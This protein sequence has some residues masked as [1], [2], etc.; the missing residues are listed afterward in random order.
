MKHRLRKWIV[1]LIGPVLFIYLLSTCDLR[2]IARILTQVRLWPFMF[3]LILTLGPIMTRYLRWRAINRGLGISVPVGKEIAIHLAS[4][5][6][7]LA[8]PGRLGEFVKLHFLKQLS[9]AS[10]L[11]FASVFADRLT[12]VIWLLMGSTAA[13]IIHFFGPHFTPVPA[14]FLAVAGAAAS[15]LLAWAGLL[16]AVSQGRRW[17]RSLV[18]APYWREPLSWLSLAWGSMTSLSKRNWAKSG[19]LTVLAWILQMIQGYL[20][21]VALGLHV[22]VTDIAIAL[23]LAAL[24][25]I[26]PISIAGIG[27]R[28]L[29]L[30][31]FLGAAGVGRSGALSL[32]IC[33]LIS[34][35]LCLAVGASAAATT[36]G[37]IYQAPEGPSPGPGEQP[38]HSG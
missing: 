19:L 6:M 38:K 29:A 36:A 8:T 20:Y 35:L 1:R 24:A 23:T 15:A 28:D 3:A 26:L 13:A 18:S 22:N 25:S 16:L 33:I 10:S 31:Y 37:K 17:T 27:S 32:S 9:H 7:G 11:A 5:A 21:C 2:Q 30:V 12:D 14:G 34:A 4:G